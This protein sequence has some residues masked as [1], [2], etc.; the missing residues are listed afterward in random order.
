MMVIITIVLCARIE[1][2]GLFYV[3]WF[4]VNIN[5]TLKHI[6]LYSNVMLHMYIHVHA[7]V[8]LREI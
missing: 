1:I 6:H 2:C 5:A 8:S 3:T 7:N 4:K